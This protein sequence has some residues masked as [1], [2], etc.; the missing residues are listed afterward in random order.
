MKIW[1]TADGQTIHRVLSGRSNAFLLSCEGNHV[2]IDTGRTNSFRRLNRNLDQLQ[3]PKD[4]LAALVL[5]HAHFDH[6]EN[7]RRMQDTHQT[8][9]IIQQEES[10]DLSRGANPVIHGTNHLTKALTDLLGERVLALAHYTP[11]PADTTFDETLDLNPFGVNAYLLHTPGH[12]PGSAS[13]IVNREIA[14]V[15]DALIGEFPNAVFPPFAD[16]P[17][18]MI[19][20]WKKLLD[21][22]CS[23]FLPAHGGG[24]TRELL[25]REYEKYRKKV[26][27]FSGSSDQHPI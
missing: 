18:I 23:L 8:A 17:V 16:Q 15:G 2:L 13:V 11:A 10:N 1:H 19:Q 22:G 14:L 21:T 26:Q 24:I 6:A 27:A 9:L 7:A 4:G 12:S 3:V 20:S 25:Q 5:T